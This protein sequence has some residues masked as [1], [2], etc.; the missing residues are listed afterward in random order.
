MNDNK[1]KIRIQIQQ[2]PPQT[3]EQLYP[4]L[5]EPEII[6]EQT[7]DWGKIAIAAI[8]LF[9][10]VVLISY[11]L[12]SSSEEPVATAVLP[13]ENH[14]TPS[15]NTPA[16]QDIGQSDAAP[17]NNAS[18]TEFN[19]SQPD[20]PITQ[21][22]ANTTYT[23]G[24]TVEAPPLNIPAAKPKSGMSSNKPIIMPRKKPQPPGKVISRTSSDRP[25]IL[26]AQLS[27]AIKAREPVDIVESVQLQPGESKPIFFYVHL[28]DLQDQKVT[29]QWYH[30][31][32]LDSQLPVRI[33]GNNWRTH[34][35]KQLDHERLGE[36]R[37]EVV[38]HSGNLLAARH[39]DVSQY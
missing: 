16:A 10:A 1:L 13:S 21:S 39:F 30:G 27:H 37:V 33:G 3:I 2:Q 26:R 22:P 32:K 24:N 36:W 20:H 12:F 19:Q 38:D 28:R 25:E 31:N 9:C 34:A 4:D 7:Y 35:S 6:Y 8:G 11:L 15:E 5:A 29:I 18:I 14:L 17:S 23:K